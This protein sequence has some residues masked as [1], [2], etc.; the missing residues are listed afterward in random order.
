MRSAAAEELLNC[1]PGCSK[2]EFDEDEEEEVPESGA[3]PDEPAAAETGVERVGLVAAG[4]SSDHTIK[5]FSCKIA[6]AVRCSFFFSVSSVF[7]TS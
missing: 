3:E 2:P 7:L 6:A 4:I 5:I 1:P